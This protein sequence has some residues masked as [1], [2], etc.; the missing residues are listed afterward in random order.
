MYANVYKHVYRDFTKD[1]EEYQ[2]TFVVKQRKETV[3]D[4]EK[5]CTTT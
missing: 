3:T 2:D 1:E 5:C 4:L